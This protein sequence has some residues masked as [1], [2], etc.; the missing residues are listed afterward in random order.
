MKVYQ[1]EAKAISIVI[2]AFLFEKYTVYPI[3]KLHAS[4]LSN[5][6]RTSPNPIVQFSLWAGGQHSNIPIWQSP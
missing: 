4:V 2:T 6:I 5:K 1:M 3:Y